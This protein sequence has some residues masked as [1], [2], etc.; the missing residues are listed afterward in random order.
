MAARSQEDIREDR[1]VAILFLVLIGA[2]FFYPMAMLWFLVTVP[3]GVAVWTV[4]GVAALALVAA[5]VG[6]I[7]EGWIGA[8]MPGVVLLFIAIAVLLDVVVGIEAVPWWLL[9]V[10]AVPAIATL[11]YWGYAYVQ[12]RE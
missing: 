6:L 3:R 11:A 4:G 10:S 8:F 9:G 12:L 5:V 1:S 7:S 2:Q